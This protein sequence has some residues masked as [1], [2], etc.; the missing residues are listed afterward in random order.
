MDN[1]RVWLTVAMDGEDLAARA[2]ALFGSA[3]QEA[4][5]ARGAFYVAIPGGRTPRRFFELLARDPQAFVW[6]KIHV[7]WTD[8]RCVPPDHVDSNYRLAADT[9]LARVPIPQSN[10]H[11]IPMDLPTACDALRSYEQTLREVFQFQEDGVPLF[12]LVILGM[13]SDGHTA[14]LFPYS[15]AVKDEEALVCRVSRPEGPGRITLTAPVLRA[16]RQIVV[17][18]SGSDKSFILY[19]VLKG[20]P[21]PLR[22]PIHVLWSV[23]DKVTWLVDQDAVGA[24]AG[25]DAKVVSRT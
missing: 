24:G 5:A 9:F 18:V 2:L 25:P 16:A 11:P 7:F 20:E 19:R 1:T 8:E 6:S 22:Y 21:D 15:Y 14:S 12:D 17:L 13:G 3:A 10:V 23:L 4:I